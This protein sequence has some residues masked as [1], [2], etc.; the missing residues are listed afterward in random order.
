L[1]P[2]SARRVPS[3]LPAVVAFGGVVMVVVA[4][5]VFTRYTAF[6]GY[7][8]LLPVIGASL[9]IY[10]ASRDRW[11]PTTVFR[12]RPVQHLG[13]VSYSVYL[14]H[15][16]L[17]ALAPY[18]VG[19]VGWIDA[20]AIVALT[21]ILA[22]LTKVFVEDRFRFAASLQRLIP[23]YRLAAA[24]MAAVTL[25]AV[26][27]LVE[28]NVRVRSA[29]AHLAIA[30]LAKDKC[31]G[32]AS[33]AQGFDVCPQ[34]P[35]GPMV[36]EPALANNDRPDAY[37]DGCW[38]AAPF[39][40][41]KTCTYGHGATRVALVGNSHAGQ[42]LPALQVL[43][44]RHGWTITTFLVPQCNATDA[45]LKFDTDEKTAG[46][47]AYGQ[48]VREQTAG[49]KFDLVIT[50]QRQSV[51]VQSTTGATTVDAAVRGYTSYLQAWSGAGTNVLVLRDSP[52]PTRTLQSV[53]DCL[54]QHPADHDA[55]A[56]TPASWYRMDPLEQAAREASL[57][58]ITTVDVLP[59][60]C[61]ET[62]C[63]AIIGS[64]VA[65]SDAIHITA[66]YA[67]TL[68]PYLDGPISAALARRVG[69]GLGRAP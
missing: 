11:S 36:P 12:L 60:F 49:V 62:R 68:A 16:P 5:V 61:T 42:W 13:D 3:G 51:G 66:T 4:A 7:A 59:W 65:Y 9:V 18:V 29:T 55:C 63:P 10:A 41:R 40:D 64:V 19:R 31:F 47:L 8:A 57:P 30:E 15:W 28:V 67:R 21:L 6:P 38:S 1:T 45:P 46:C 2:L 25:L 23:T 37:A 52:D 44:E 48:W 17:I 22:T 53:P 14:W 58:G 20:L 43:A 24:G 54:A 39:T 69:G 32:A 50:S 27:Q 33:I 26:V 35:A 34:N 56:G